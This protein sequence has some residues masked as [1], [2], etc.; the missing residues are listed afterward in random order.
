MEEGG[1][2]DKKELRNIAP[3]YTA[4]E[5]ENIIFLHAEEGETE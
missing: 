4:R 3:K 5:V 2:N 1:Q